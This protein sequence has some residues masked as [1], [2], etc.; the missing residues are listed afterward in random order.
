MCGISGT[1]YYENAPSNAEESLLLSLQCIATR[2]PDDEGLYHKGPVWFG[3]RRLSVIDVS[4]NAHQP[5]SDSTGRY[6]IIYNGEIFNYPELRAL[7]A[8][9]GVEF[10]SKS[11]TEVLLYL[12]IKEG[13]ACLHRLNGFFAFAIHDAEKDEIWIVRD[14]FGVKPL[15]FFADGSSFHFASEVKQFIARGLPAELDMVSLHLYL[16][17][18]YVPGPWSMLKNI[19]QVGPGSFI[20]VSARDKRYT[21]EKWY[22]LKQDKRHTGSYSD[23]CKGL[24]EKM[25]ASVRRRM[26]SDVPLGAFL[27]GGVDS[28]II[29]A[30]AARETKS[31][32]TFSI[33]FE[34]EPHFDE[35]QFARLVAKHCGTEHR[36]YRLKSADLLNALP[37]VLDYFGEP[38]ADS[39]ALAVY[40]LSRETRK[41]VT[42]ALSGDGSDEI[43]AGY[44]K[45]RAEWLLRN[46][47]WLSPVSRVTSP[48]LGRFKGSRQSR[49][50]NLLR[51]VHRFAEGVS[52]SPATRYWRWCSI[53]SFSQAAELMLDHRDELKSE[54]I[55]R[56]GRFTKDIHGKD[57]NE[58]LYSDVDLVLPNDMLVKVDLMS[59]ANSLEVR[60]PFLDKDVVEF[61]FSLPAE[62]KIDGNS[63]KKILKDTFGH[64]LPQEIFSRKKQGFEIPMLRWLRKDLKD[65]VEGLLNEKFLSQ[66]G[67]FKP[68]AVSALRKELYSDNPGEATA[69]IWA[70]VVFQHWWTKNKIS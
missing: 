33:G 36:E 8:E 22:R 49:A 32:H 58:I 38:F 17:L 23:A 63:Q 13:V 4:S 9:E 34:D 24:Y 15:Y 21:Q 52:V 57:F 35:T 37:E 12:F 27:S 62:Y 55:E 60:T 14:R 48:V 3:H 5:F 69:R 26:I 19:S 31:L 41:H 40:I 1:V 50:G 54:S 65:I 67:I 11:D 2:G 39:S 56:S 44:K 43:F 18:N 51:Q 66:Q 42:V 6:T 16:Q 25:Q 46:Y 30:L 53:A 28:S 61:A 29:A 64:L 59:M 45:H 70:L 47:R 20:H 7:L 68:S 10:R